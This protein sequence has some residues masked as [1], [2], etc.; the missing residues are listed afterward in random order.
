MTFGKFN[1]EWLA[2]ECGV[3]LTAKAVTG[4]N[5]E[6]VQAE[7]TLVNGSEKAI[8][9]A[10]ASF[11][12]QNA[13]T[14]GAAAFADVAAGSSATV[15]VPVTIPASA[16][17]G[18]YNVTA[19]ASYGTSEFSAVVA[20]TV[21]GGAA[22]TLGLDVVGSRTDKGRDLATTPYT[23]GEKLPYQFAVTSLSNVTSNVAPVSGNFD[24]F[25]PPAGGN[26]RW[27]NLGMWANYTCGTPRHAVTA[28]EL[29]NGFFVPLT[30]WSASAPAWKP[31][32]SP[33]R[34]SEVDVLVRNPRT[35]GH[36]GRR[37]ERRRRQRPGRCRRH[38]HHHRHRQPTPATSP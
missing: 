20:V 16:K 24:P 6:T 12:A 3:E 33:S 2:I 11:A 31:R 30:T 21:T 5:G 36:R 9:G 13:W 4:A 17:A 8:T 10:K 19:K 26:C 23:V 14:F 32:R 27:N 18:S 37:V 28:D 15:T 22:P 35:V 34:A 29:A 38:R 7:L 25:L 1:A